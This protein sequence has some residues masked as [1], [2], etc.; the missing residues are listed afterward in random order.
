MRNSLDIH[1]SGCTPLRIKAWTC[2]LFLI[3]LGSYVV[4][5]ALKTTFCRSLRFSQ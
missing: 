2:L 5:C 1:M 4:L 3:S